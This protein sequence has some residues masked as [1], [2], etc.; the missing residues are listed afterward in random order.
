MI[1]AV[2]GDCFGGG[3]EIALRADVIIATESA[4]FRHPEAT[5]GVITLLGGVQRVAERAGRAR[6]ARW[7]LTA[8]PVSAAEALA[9]GVIAE[10]VPDDEL[11]STTARWAQLLARG[12]TRPHAAH[13]QLLQ[14]WSDGGVEAADALIPELTTQLMRTE[15]AQRGS[16]RQWMRSTRA[17]P[18]PMSRSL[19]VDGFSEE[20]G[21]PMPD[22]PHAATR[23]EVTAWFFEDYL[24]RWVA[25]G[26][27]T[28]AEGPEFILNYWSTPMHVTGLDQSFWCLDDASLL[29][30]LELNYAPCASRGT[31][32]PWCRTA[33]SSSTA[34][35]G[36][37]SRSSC[38]AGAPMSEIQRAATHFEVA[39]SEQRWRV[40]G[41][42]SA[43]TS[44]DS[45][46]ARWPRA[47]PPSNR[48]R[49]WCF[50]SRTRGPGGT[51][52]LGA[53]GAVVKQP[54]MPPRKENL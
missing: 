32:A 27:G 51:R 2:Q 15:D 25:A 20:T 54:D 31:A 28:S 1:A 5:L 40:V 29:G 41:I 42:Q 6:A 47:R 3:F 9:A 35:S 24:P 33:G 16:R 45:L 19:V 52:R 39:K 17:S 36:R 48:R 38:R 10:V 22:D 49:K 7:A 50:A 11:E 53:A 44:A 34:R 46:E 12:A 4:R 43:A 13:K 37:R 30:L 26:A 14:A 8:E 18:V 21:A 23:A